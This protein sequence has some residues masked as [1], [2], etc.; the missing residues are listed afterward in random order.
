MKKVFIYLTIHLTSLIIISQFIG[1]VAFFYLEPIS[2][3]IYAIYYFLMFLPF[4]WVLTGWLDK[5]EWNIFLKV[6]TVTFSGTL[7]T[8]F[9]LQ[10]EIYFYSKWEG[11]VTNIGWFLDEFWK[12]IYYIF[13]TLV[14]AELTRLVLEK[15]KN[16]LVFGLI[17]ITYLA[18]IIYG[19]WIFYPGKAPTD[20]PN[21]QQANNGKPN[22]IIILADDLGY[23]D[24]SI[25]GNK[26]IQTPHIDAIGKN[27]VI[28]TRGYCSAP[29]CAPS[30]AGML[31]GRYQQR[32]G[33]EFLSDKMAAHPRV[34]Q[35]DFANFGNQLNE[36]SWFEAGNIRNRGIEHQ[37]TTLAELL[38]QSGYA[39][40][41]I[42]KWHLGLL[43]RFHPDK[44]GFDYHF[45][46]YNAAALYADA[47]DPKMVISKHPWD[48]VDNLQ[49]RVLNYEVFENSQVLDFEYNE[50]L[51]DVL[52]DKCVN[53]IDEHKKEQFF[54]YAAFTA[55][56]S[57]F[58]APKE[59]YDKLS[60]IKDH[61]RRVYY[62]MI[63]S[64]DQAVGQIVKKLKEEG[65]YEN[66]IIF[67]SS[68]NGGA[69]Y[70]R[71]CDNSPFF[72]GKFTEYEGGLVVPFMMSWPQKLKN[73]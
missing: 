63:L 70:T 28:F 59:I 53:Y 33:F 4:L 19:V 34:R 27:G 36:V 40:G 67:F 44:H 72:G 26:F 56:H 58:Q 51:T 71:A 39:T 22:V 32:F 66:T 25:N 68:D 14:I 21:I 8:Y 50:Y 3:A 52:A 24:I 64:L 47:N 30:R 10:S 73:Q 60:H 15:Q 13:P 11:I 42:G 49:W 23:N 16:I 6:L 18:I 43:P 5:K 61:N 62:S 46:I 31:T 20:L 54:L 7:L 57:P 38:K 1:V 55:P 37:E 17:S 35:A 2:Q 41:I 29:V 69:T 12:S 45:G 9:F 65:L 48:F